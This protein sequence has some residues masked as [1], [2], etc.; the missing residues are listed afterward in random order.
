MRVGPS[1]P[2]RLPKGPLSNGDQPRTSANRGGAIPVFTW[3]ADPLF[4]YIWACRGMF[5]PKFAYA[6]ATLAR[7]APSPSLIEGLQ[8]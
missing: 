6:I 7:G 3:I 4:L 1:L 5:A 8:G 2:R